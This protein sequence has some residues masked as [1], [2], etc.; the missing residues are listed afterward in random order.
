MTPEEIEENKD[1]TTTFNNIK[2]YKVLNY[3][4]IINL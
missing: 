4:N 3:G 1:L 2:L